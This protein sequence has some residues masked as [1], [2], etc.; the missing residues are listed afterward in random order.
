MSLSVICHWAIPSTLS[1]K[2]I[3]E[4]FEKLVKWATVTFHI[5]ARHYYRDARNQLPKRYFAVEG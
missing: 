5:L 3:D 2:C 1:N 4:E